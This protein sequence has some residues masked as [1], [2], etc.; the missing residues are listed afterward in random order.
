M[1]NSET[2]YSCGACS[3][4]L[5]LGVGF[6]T[7]ILLL[8]IGPH[9]W[10]AA[11]FL[12][13][14]IFV[15]L[16][17]LFSWLFCAPLP[18]PRFQRT[19]PVTVTPA[20]AATQKPETAVNPGPTTPTKAAPAA[21]PVE[22]SASDTGKP[23]LHDAPPD[24]VDDLKKIKGVGPKLEQALNQLGVFQLAQIAGWSEQEIA[25]VDEN[26]A[27]FKGRILRD[28]WVDQ[29]KLLAQG[30]ETEFSKKVSDGEVY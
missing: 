17:M 19:T 29:A 15:I 10:I 18:E 1:A 2:A 25:W 20:Q 24:M 21:A 30:G 8:A 9:S 14:L 23:T 22:Q 7:T 5:A 13:G 11:F 26:L 12:G 16:G 4:G 27:A 6:V 3:W 28:N